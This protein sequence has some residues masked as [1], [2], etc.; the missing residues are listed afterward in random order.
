MGSLLSTI[1]FFLVAL[2][3]LITVHEFGHFWVA[4]W[5][6]VKVLRFSIGFGRPLWRRQ[7]RRDGTEYVIAMLPLGGY[8]KMLDEREEPV[9]PAELPRAFNRQSLA[10]RAAIVTAGPAFNLLFAVLAY[11]VVMVTGESG[12]RPILGEVPAASMAERGGFR[13]GDEILTIGGRPTP[14]WESV[15]YALLAGS[16]GPG[17]ISVRVRNTAGVEDLRSIPGAA[18]LD[19]AEG[20]QVLRE[21]GL[22]PYRPPLQPIIGEVLPGEAAEQA[23][24]RAGDRLLA[25]DGQPVTDWNA[26]VE[27]VRAAPERTLHLEAE[28]AGARFSLILIP[29]AV[30]SDEGRI[31]RVGASVAV[32][33]GAFDEL[34]AE[35]RYGPVEAIG[36]AVGR[37]WDM[38]ALMLRMLGRMVIGTASIKNLSGPISIADSA[39]RSA[40][41]GPGFFLK[42]LAVVSISL[43]VLNLLPIP[44]LD[45]GHLL[46]FFVEAVRGRPLSE[47]ALEIG[48][49]I[50]LAFLLALTTLAFYLDIARLLG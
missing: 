25:V 45:G 48:Q 22:T 12:A 36:H 44:V 43:G 40:R 46:Y 35:V 27:R 11:W 28:R 29:Q 9:A 6:G 50:G 38:A 33:E 15:I 42:F 24:L 17:E 26:W 10:V 20:G 23:G 4:R 31:G 34:R 16:L 5:L 14:T 2:G 7:G 41:H 30:E 32:P 8:V 39:G 49:R 18:V 19:R 21:L 47:R 13:P 1:F 3:V 37:T